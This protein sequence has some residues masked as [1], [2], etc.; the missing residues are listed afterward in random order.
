[1]SSIENAPPSMCFPT[2]EGMRK[3]AEHQR[4]LE[5]KQRIAN[6]QRWGAYLS[7]RQW[8]TVREDYSENQEAWFYFPHDHARSRAYRWGEDGLL[9]ICDREG[10]LCFSFAFWNTRDPI[11]KERLYGLSGPEG[12][13]GEDVKECYYYLDSTPTHS[14]MK[15]LYKYPQAKFPYDNITEVNRS[16]SRFEEEHELL[17]TEAFDANAYFDCE[18][19]YAKGDPNDILIQLTVHNR[20]RAPAVLHVLPQLWFHNSWIWGC[21]HEGC[22]SKPRMRLHKSA[23]EPNGVV[24]CDHE[25]LGHFEFRVDADSE[26]QKPNWLFTENETN[27]N[28]HPGVPT[29]GTFFKD[30]FHA[31]VVNGDVNGTDTRTFGTKCAAHYIAVI[32]PNEPLV[33]RCRL[34]G[35]GTAEIEADPSIEQP[36]MNPIFGDCRIDRGFERALERRRQE[37]DEF[38][39]ECIPQTLNSQEQAISRQAYAGLLWTKQFYYYVVDSWIKGD[40]NSPPP[41]RGREVG[42]N[43]DWLHLF[44]RDVIS[45]PDKWEYP[46][47][48][49]WDVAFHMI[50]MARVDIEFAKNQ[51]ILF[52]REWYM[53]PNGQIPAY[54]WALNDVNPPVHAW[55]CWH[56][57]K[58]SGDKEFLA[59]T[60]QKLLLNFTWWVNRKDTRGQ[61]VFSGGFLGLDNIG[62]FD[63]SKPL[64]G[65]GT[66][67]QADATAWMAFFCGCMLQMAL[68]LAEENQ[69]YSDMASK[70]FEHYIAIAEAMNSLHGT[71]LWEENDGFY[72]DHLYHDGKSTAMRVRSLVGLIPL[73]SNV[74][75]YDRI[76]QRLPSFQ[77]RMN[78]FLKNRPQVSKHMAYMEHFCPEGSNSGMRL[79]AIPSTERFRRLLS[80]MLDEKE[81]LSPFGIR[82]LSAIHK[83]KPFVFERAGW[84]ESVS[85]VPGES[86]TGM[87]GGNS[88]WR[89]PVWFPLNYLI[90]ESLRQ[91]HE[92]YGETFQVECPTG[93]GTLMNLRQVADEIERRL[94][95]LFQ[96]DATGRR[97]CHGTEQQYAQLDDWKELVL[98]YEYFHGDTGRGLGA[99]HQTGWTALV[100]TMLEHQS[101]TV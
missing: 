100:A 82:S 23:T 95:T 37:S 24:L 25:S 3:T 28:R 99:S 53:H 63:R 36:I 39:R 77:R 61:H 2:S 64:P 59:R 56:I 79:L 43:I 9:G 94:I 96:A 32:S 70:F 74:I 97:P 55:A 46:W 38:Y 12:N 34:T 50:P 21:E 14:Y 83:E 67:D 11:L 54:E 84:R 30:A 26:G 89:G 22:E 42:R 57:Y 10:R 69:A 80:Y 5:S 8:G 41:P 35:K 101:N 19:E 29:S 92:F 18:I 15:G 45:M 72:Y 40:P 65:G 85:Y 62:V 87:F 86:N 49:A 7:E 93:S 78:W 81:F 31:S 66:L 75:M 27:P 6:W 60:F 16:R 17:N 33:I 20:G 4:L 90:V 98:F 1:M 47:Y 76:L 51:L 44:N 91:Y 52:L 73:C 88:N 71:G 68:E 58:L 13:H 48:A